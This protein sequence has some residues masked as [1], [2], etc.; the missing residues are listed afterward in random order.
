MF[1]PLR[2]EILLQVHT[3]VVNVGTSV[4]TRTDGTLEPTRVQA[5]ADQLQR[6]RAT[7]RLQGI[8]KRFSMCACT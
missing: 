7:G 5:L 3:V 4:L 2:Q 8:L 6:I 1:D